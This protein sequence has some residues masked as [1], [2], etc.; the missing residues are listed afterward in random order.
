M[1]CLMILPCAAGATGLRAVQPGQASVQPSVSGNT[2]R[3]LPVAA[4][5]ALATA[6]A[7]DGAPGSPTPVG[8]S[9]RRHD[10]HL[11]RRHLVDAQRRVVVEVRLLDDAV[12]ERDRAV[13]RGGQAEADAAFH[14]RA[15]DVG[16]DRDAAIDGADDAVDAEAAVALT[17]TSATCATNV[18]NDSCTATPRPRFRPLAGRA[19]FP[20]R[21]SPR[22][23]RARRDGAD[24]SAS[25]RARN[26]TGS[27]PAAAASS[28]MKVSVENAVCVEPTERHHSTGTPTFG[29]CRSTC[30]FGIA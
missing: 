24:G 19:A 29:V 13:Q 14:L 20:S 6:G 15:D 2:R 1:N 25:K 26:A 16:V 12:L 22:R 17:V 3:R 11:D 9:A 28:S 7:I 18:L 27:L 10:M 5:M 30:R 4:E 23:V 21:P 8:G